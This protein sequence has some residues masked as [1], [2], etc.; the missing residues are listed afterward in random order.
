MI[1]PRSAKPA[2]KKSAPAIPGSAVAPTPVFLETP[3]TFSKAAYFEQGEVLAKIGVPRVDEVEFSYVDP[4]HAYLR[5]IPATALAAPLSFAELRAAAT[6]APLLKNRLGA[7]TTINR[8]GGFAYDPAGAYPG[9]P[10]PLHWSTQLF[11]NGEM[12]AVS[13]TM[14]IRDRGSRPEWLPL[15]LLPA[16][17]FEQIYYEVAHVGVSF[18]RAHLGLTFP[19][20]LEFGLLNI[21]GMHVGI[22]NE[23]IRGAIQVAEAVCRLTVEAYEVEAV[24]AALLTFFNQVHDLTGYR[25]PANLHGFPPNRPHG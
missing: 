16:T 15:P 18:A 21:K 17:L 20:H 3:T 9:G 11:R 7:L 25:R 19:C 10:A 4:P 8:H 24:N 14:I 13:N 5:I 12:W 2:K 23:D 22:T 6:H 1:T